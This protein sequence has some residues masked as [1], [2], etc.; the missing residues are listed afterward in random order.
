MAEGI[1]TFMGLGLPL[2][3]ESEIKQQS[4]SYDILTLTSA[5][6][7][8]S[9]YLVFQNSDGT[10]LMRIEDDGRIW[11]SITGTGSGN[12][13]S[14]RTMDADADG[15]Y[16]YAAQF[17]LDMSTYD[18]GGGRC[19][20]LYLRFDDSGL[21]SAAAKS[22]INF[23]EHGTD[24]PTLFTFPSLTASSGG[25]FSARSSITGTHGFQIYVGTTKYYIVVAETS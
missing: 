12:I 2:N 9:D 1:S 3:G 6:S 11:Q 10:E 24:L 25:C 17:L 20:T 7:N 8:T 15:A 18:V 5:A 19:S 13:G 22:F 23:E 4:I 21:G 16:T 14:Y